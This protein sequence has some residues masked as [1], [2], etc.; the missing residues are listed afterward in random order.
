MRKRNIKLIFTLLVMCL[1][2]HVERNVSYTMNKHN[3]LQ[4]VCRMCRYALNRLKKNGLFYCIR[5][6]IVEHRRSTIENKVPNE[7]SSEQKPKYIRY[8]K[9]VTCKKT[10]INRLSTTL[11]H[12]IEINGYLHGA[13]LLF[14]LVR[15]RHR[16]N[17][18]M[19]NKHVCACANANCIRSN[20]KIVFDKRQDKKKI[21]FDASCEFVMYWYV[22]Y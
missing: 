18:A 21:A 11:L 2:L 6:N 13:K 14:T 7:M 4:R 20:G 17:D 15:D 16:T 5:W 1:Q 22:I 19:D 8:K 9:N 3:G 12:S 10:E